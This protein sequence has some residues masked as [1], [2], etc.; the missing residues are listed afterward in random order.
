MASKCVFITEWESY[1]NA[2]C[3]RALLRRCCPRPFLAHSPKWWKPEDKARS[4]QSYTHYSIWCKARGLRCAEKKC[5]FFLFTIF[6]Y[7][8]SWIQIISIC[9]QSRGF[10]QHH[11]NVDKRA[12][13]SQFACHIHTSCVRSCAHSNSWVVLP[14]TQ[15]ATFTEIHEH[16][17]LNWKSH[18]LAQLCNRTRSHRNCD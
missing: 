13:P 2:L 10:F 16:L 8:G 12:R 1:R 14:K 6:A 7:H 11:F 18:L 5:L 15:V 3:V 4:K 17:Y 9:R